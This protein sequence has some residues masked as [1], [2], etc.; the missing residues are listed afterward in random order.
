VLPL[1]HRT[2]PHQTSFP[3]SQ[4]QSK[5]EF[6][7]RAGEWHEEGYGRSAP[8]P[9]A[10]LTEVWTLNAAVRRS[11]VFVAAAA[12]PATLLLQRTS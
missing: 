8:V 4:A 10:A 5:S 7:L 11:V 9:A 2:M 12:E 6:R 3:P 1:H